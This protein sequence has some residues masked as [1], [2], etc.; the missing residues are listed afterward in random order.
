MWQLQ[1]KRESEG[2]SL[3]SLSQNKKVLKTTTNFENNING[4]NNNNNNN[5]EWEPE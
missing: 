3:L 5:S 1:R 2:Y 4:F